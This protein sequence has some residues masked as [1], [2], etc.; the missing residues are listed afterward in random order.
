MLVEL[1]APF[2]LRLEYICLE[3]QQEVQVHTKPTLKARWVLII[4]TCSGVRDPSQV[5]LAFGLCDGL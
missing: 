3:I 5:R 2:G 4:S 1:K